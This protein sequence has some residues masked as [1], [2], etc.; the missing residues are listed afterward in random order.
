MLQKSYKNVTK[1]TYLSNNEN[2]DA[3]SHPH[4]EYFFI[5]IESK[6]SLETLCFVGAD[7]GTMMSDFT[8][9]RSEQKSSGCASVGVENGLFGELL[10]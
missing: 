10:G 5:V 1:S 7:P 3:F 9:R 2:F 8:K 6:T 4:A